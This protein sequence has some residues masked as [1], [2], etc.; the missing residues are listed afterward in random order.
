M[1]MGRWAR[2]LM[3][4]AAP[5]TVCLSAGLLAG[6]G[7]FW[8]A[9]GGGS[10]SFT[11]TNSGV[12]TVSPGASGTSTITVT[13]A[14]SFTGAVTL[15]C[16][17]TNSPAGAANLPTCNLNPTSV[18]ISGTTAQTSTLTADTA[19]GT[20]SGAYQITVTG[21]SGSTSETTAVCVAVGSSSGGC[22]N[23]AG[24]SGNFYILNSSTISGYSINAGTLTALS[25]SPYSLPTGGG[26]GAAMAIDPTSPTLLYVATTG[27][28][29]LYS[30]E[31]SGALSTPT[32]ISQ[33]LG[34]TAIQVDPSGK[35]LLVAYSSG[36]L[37]AIPIT[38]AGTQDS[39]RSVQ[40]N[41]NLAGTPIQMAISPS[42]TNAIVAVSL[43]SSGTQV[44]PFSTGNSA[45]IGNA[46]TPTIAPWGATNSAASAQSVAID[47]QNRFLYIGEVAAFPNST[48]ST[49]TGGLRVLPI[50]SGSVSGISTTPTPSGGTG[51]HAILPE[52]SGNYV[53]VANWAGNATGVGFQVA[54]NGALTQ[55]SST[56]STGSEP[57]GLAEDNT[58]GFVLVV[59]G[60]GSP[61]FDAYSFSSSTGLLTS[62]ISSSS[63]GTNSV[64]IVAVP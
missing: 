55:L 5:V 52:S 47:P 7:D 27:G 25:G 62:G 45:P 34:V 42:Q 30:I 15:T 20:T 1:R 16:A 43:G 46:Y 19:S 39:T 63:T 38:S 26:V 28:I 11:L 13:P 6:C 31:S 3:L 54:S 18:T 36:S 24:T 33:V 4:A 12:I 37:S 22:S 29:F 58:D 40:A 10:N 49:G 53:Y 61:D 41:T 8:Q 64:A 44:F 9:P 51:P 17:V 32:T 2:R 21:V 56:F 23:T 14:N 35:W 60:L 57:T 50:G 59:S 48:A